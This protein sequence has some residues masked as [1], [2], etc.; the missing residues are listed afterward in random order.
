M[1]KAVRKVVGKD[2]R[3]GKEVTKGIEMEIEISRS[4]AYWEAVKRVF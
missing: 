1:R 2:V 3:T 4:G